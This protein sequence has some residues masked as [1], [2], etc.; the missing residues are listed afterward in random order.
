MARRVIELRTLGELELKRSDRD[1]SAILA[2]P[3]R[4]ALL[5]YLAVST[6]WQRR[7]SVVALF[8]PTTTPIM[9]AVRSARRSDSSDGSWAMACS[10]AVVRRKS[11]FKRARCG[12]T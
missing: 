9:L 1:L 2:Q 11:A 8:G 3:K 5:T 7:D 12:A 10:P 4:L 6:H